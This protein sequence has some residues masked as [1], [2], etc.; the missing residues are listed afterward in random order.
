[1]LSAMKQCLKDLLLTS[2]A[3][4]R[5]KLMVVLVLCDE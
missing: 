1:M 2:L 5:A 3:W 4:R